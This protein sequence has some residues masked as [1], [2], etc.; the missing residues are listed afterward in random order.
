MPIWGWGWWVGKT[1]LL[2]HHCYSA[3]SWSIALHG[4]FLSFFWSWVNSLS[5]SIAF[6]EPF[7]AFSL[8]LSPFESMTAFW[9]E[10]PL[11]FQHCGIRMWF[12]MVG[13]WIWICCAYFWFPSHSASTA[14]RPLCWR[15]HHWIIVVFP[16]CLV[17]WFC[18][19]GCWIVLW[20]SN[21]PWSWTLLPFWT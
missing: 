19:A 9:V 1:F 18:C 12:W 13:F 6:S 7:M 14:V 11:W 10:G 16:P 17:L 21:F 5:F 20:S 3:S 2:P 15:I 8:S 4:T